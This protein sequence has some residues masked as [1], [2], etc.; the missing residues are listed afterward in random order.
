MVLLAEAVDKAISDVATGEKCTYRRTLNSTVLAFSVENAGIRAPPAGLEQGWY[1]TA[2]PFL[3]A[4]L[5]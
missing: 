3:H 1:K 2:A 5:A 4:D